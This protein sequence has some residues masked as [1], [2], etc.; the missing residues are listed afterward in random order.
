MSAKIPERGEVWFA[1][2]GPVTGRE[3]ALLRPVIVVLAD[4]IHLPGLTI[5]VPT[6]AKTHRRRAGL[7]VDIPAGEAGLTEDSL[8]LCHHI[9]VVDVANKMQYRMGELDAHYM[10]SVEAA[11]ISLL[12]LPT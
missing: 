1:D 9:R 11:M 8:A 10:S 5:V 6:T 2:L 4:W 3:Q 7:T 12:D